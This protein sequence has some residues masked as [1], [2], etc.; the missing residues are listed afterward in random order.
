MWDNPPG[1]ASTL[2][3]LVEEEQDGWQVVLTFNKHFTKLNFFR[4]GVSQVSW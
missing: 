2:Y 4:D 1:L 3:I